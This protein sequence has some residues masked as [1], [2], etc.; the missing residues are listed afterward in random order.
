VSWV[1]A[2]I[3]VPEDRHAA[4]A[5]FWGEVLGWPA[6]DPWPGHPELCS[7]EPAEGSPYLHLQR[8]ESRPR[9]HLDLESAEPAA[10]VDRARDLGAR[11]VDGRVDWVTMRSPG[12][13]P[14]CVLRSSGH[15]APEPVTFADGHRAR[16]VQVCVDSPSSVHD[17]EV[18]FWR[19]LLG[20]RWVP[21]GAAEFAGKWHD[22]DGAPL[23]LLF[24]RLDEAD[25]SV[26]AHL[27]LGT[28]DL[29][30]DV[31]RLR[32]VGAQDL[33]PGRGWHVFGDPAGLRFCTTLNSPEQVRHRDLG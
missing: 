32:D 15:R 23:Q 4:V 8:A 5:G 10:T 27:D 11:R 24:Q 13:L 31:R 12:G 30:A 2:V 19:Q 25:G 18:T 21:S 14:F 28:D 9:V 17:A 16:L 22:D 6:G 1:H 3:D 33:G 29:D 20:G 26:R 7:F